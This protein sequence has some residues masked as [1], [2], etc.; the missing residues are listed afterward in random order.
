MPPVDIEDHLSL[1]L[2]AKTRE[3]LLYELGVV[4]KELGFSNYCYG[5]KS[6][7]PCTAPKIKMVNNYPLGWKKNYSENNYVDIDPLIKHGMKTMM[8]L[9]WDY[10]IFRGLGPL[11]DD[12]YQYGVHYGWTQSV[13]LREGIIGWFTVSRA[14][15]E[16]SKSEIKEKTSLLIWFN[17]TVQIGL[18]KFLLPEVTKI[19]DV[20]L[21]NR[22]AEILRWTADGKTAHEIAIILN[23]SERTI[24]FHL[25]NTMKK[26]GVSNKITAAIQAI[27]YGII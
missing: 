5:L 18:S 21:T 24:N 20:C 26:F 22:E 17:H 27:L 6:L 1:I 2:T 4:A 12:A 25:T 15:I 7:Y 16:F 10:K 9:D 14:D 3:D 8:P 11:C 13:K 19:L 23:I